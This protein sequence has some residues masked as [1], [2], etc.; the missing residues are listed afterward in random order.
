MSNG[1][2]TNRINA[3]IQV[4]SS[5]NHEAPTDGPQLESAAE[6][7]SFRSRQ[8]RLVDGV[9]RVAGRRRDSGR[10]VGIGCRQ[11]EWS[12]WIDLL[13]ESRSGQEAGCY[14]EEPETGR[15]QL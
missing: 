14:Q 12:R 8:V 15:A 5:A 13:A 6:A 9:K 4:L 11:W 2:K 1:G 7:E 3:M 10:R